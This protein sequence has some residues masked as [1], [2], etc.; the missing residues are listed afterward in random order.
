M[1]DKETLQKLVSATAKPASAKKEFDQLYLIYLGAPSKS[2]FPKL[3]GGKRSEESDGTS[4]TFSE[5]GSS[6]KVTVVYAGD[7]EPELLEMYLVSGLG[8][9][10]RS[11]NFIFIDENSKIQH[12]TQEAQK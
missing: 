7:L 6:K 5:L 12:V 10:I 11:S 1:I 3:E 2:H 4:F 9:D 8:Y